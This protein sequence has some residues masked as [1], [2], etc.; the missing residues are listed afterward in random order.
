MILKILIR[1]QKKHLKTVC[2]NCQTE[3]DNDANYC[4]KCGEK[5]E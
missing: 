3:N 2:K 4:E 5:L 1:C